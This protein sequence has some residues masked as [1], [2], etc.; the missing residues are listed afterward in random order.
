[1]VRSQS[2]PSDTH[3]HAEVSCRNPWDNYGE[4]FDRAARKQLPSTGCFVIEETIAYHR[5]RKLGLVMFTVDSE[6]NTA[7][8]VLPEREVDSRGREQER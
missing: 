5:E 1:M 7:A 3:V 2:S 8:C 4:E 6:S